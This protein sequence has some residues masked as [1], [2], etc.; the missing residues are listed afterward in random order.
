MNQQMMMRLRKMQKQLEEAQAKLQSTV[1]TGTAGGI[2]T[3][4]MKGTHEVLSV[5][6]DPEAFESKEDIEMIQDSIVSA[7]NDANRQ[8]EAE[9]AKVLGPYTS[10]GGMGGLF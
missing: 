7:I 8:L 5:E 2:V 6:I 10:M 9:T 1:F 4:K 3:V